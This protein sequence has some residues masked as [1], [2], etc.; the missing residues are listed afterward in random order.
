M[1]F[2][3]LK[4][5]VFV[6]GPDSNYVSEGIMLSKGKA[7]SYKGHP[8]LDV[9]TDSIEDPVSSFSRMSKEQ[10]KTMKLKPE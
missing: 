4:K 10:L 1:A 2:A 9:L 3:A 8:I 5:G 7:E 6:G